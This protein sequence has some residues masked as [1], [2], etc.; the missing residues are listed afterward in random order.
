[1]NINILSNNAVTPVLAFAFSFVGCL[2][3]LHSIAR[4][5]NAAGPG[6]RVG[7]LLLGAWAMAATAVWDMFLVAAIDLHTGGL[8]VRYDI[9]SIIASIAV[10]VIASAF[11]LWL[12]ALR[13]GTVGTLLAGAFAGAVMAVD[14]L[15][16]LTALRVN[17]VVSFRTA[18][19]TVVV[20]VAVI[21]TAPAVLVSTRFSRRGVL[22]VAATVLAVITTA[23]HYLCLEAID[24]TQADARTV[25]DGI[26]PTAVIVPVAIIFIVRF[27]LLLVVLLANTTTTVV[28]RNLAAEIDR[29]L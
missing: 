18:E 29:N 15:R 28:P 12:A 3:A 9:I 6:R 2:L 5:T 24:L 8:P 10:S 19:V 21:T 22:A 17:A 11:V 4:G 7:W 25:T 13:A 1:V 27:A 26:V 23:T 14:G 20:V 16:A